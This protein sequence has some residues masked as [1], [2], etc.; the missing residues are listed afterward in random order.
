MTGPIE[1]TSGKVYL[2]VVIP[3]PLRTVFDYEMAVSDHT[4]EPVPG[5]RVLVPFGKYDRVGL[6]T[7]S[8]PTTSLPGNKI[9]SVHEVI[10]Q[11]P[12]LNSA[13]LTLAQWASKYYHHSLGDIFFSMLPVRLRQKRKFSLPT[14][15]FWSLLP[16]ADRNDIPANAT[17]QRQCLD[18]IAQRNTP[19]PE[20]ELIAAGISR[21]ILGRLSELKQIQ[22]EQ[23]LDETLPSTTENGPRLTSEQFNAVKHVSLDG[24]KSYV[25]N[26]I[27]GSGK[28]EVYLQLVEQTINRGKQ[29]LLLVPEIGLTPQTVNRF[30]SRI[31]A[32]VRVLHSN[33]KDTEAMDIWSLSS[34][35][36]PQVVIATRSGL[37]AP[38]PELGLILVDEEHDSSYKQQSGWMYSARDLAIVRAKQAGIPVVLGSATPSLESWQQ[39]KSGAYH[40]LPLTQRPKNQ[41]EPDFEVLDIRKLPLEQGLSLPLLDRI[42]QTLQTGEQVLVF[43]NRR[44]YA[45][46]LMC[47]DCGWLAECERCLSQFTLHHQ[48]RR[49]ICHHCESSKPVPIHCPDCHSESVTP[50][51]QGTERIE[52]ALRRHFSKYN[53]A[54]IDRD[55]TRSRGAMSDYIEA[56]KKGE[57]QLLIGTQ[58]LAKGHHFPNL[59]LVVIVDMDGAL[60]SADF[61]ATERFGQLLKQVSGRAGRDDKKG[62]VVIQTRQ[63]EHP[64]LLQLLRDSY[65]HFSNEL[66]NE[67]KAAHWPP[68]THLALLKAEATNEQKPADFLSTVKRIMTPSAQHEK[69]QLLGPVPAL[70]QKRAGKYRFQLLIQSQQRQSLHLLLNQLVETIESQKLAKSVRW[71]LDV[72]P[73]DLV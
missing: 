29:A 58:M 54:R 3:G 63:P 25:L 26:G 70:R 52:E 11:K 18:L 23:Q 14:K 45:P 5:C 30:Q 51:G 15:T 65:A 40:E 17:K 19:V 61:R 16:G 38:L 13:Q 2:Q 69:I 72:D 48:K 33:L 9:K 32:P 37:F 55:S 62:R 8:S 59:S 41:Q 73:V 21:Q 28:T 1:N 53:I 42:G 49:L 24:F 67:R 31:N 71:T 50:V 10:D 43:L 12:V 6:V 60:F 4:P 47:H 56:I 22:S 36:Q 34:L 57:Y 20:T 64:L 35:D 7:G 39:V 46:V 44:G 68:F 66:L 27:T